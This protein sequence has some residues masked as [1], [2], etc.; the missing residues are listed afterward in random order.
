MKLSNH[1]APPKPPRSQTVGFLLIPGFALMSYSS[2]MEPLRAANHLSGRT[3]Y[4]WK[5]VSPDGNPVPASNGVQ[6]IPDH[7]VGDRIALDMLFV[8]AGGNPA[9]FKDQKTLQ[10][11]RG[12]ARKGTK[13][14]GVSGGPFILARAGLLSGHRCTIHWEHV[15]AFLEEFPDVDLT[16]TLFEADG[17]RLTCAGGI[18][19]L[20]MMNAIIEKVHGHALANSVSEWFLHT[21]VRA[22]DDPQRMAL[23][24]RFAVS[25]D[26]LLRVLE[27][28]EANLEGPVSRSELARIAKLS[29]RQLE[30]L[31]QTHLKRTLKEH[32]LDLRLGRARQ[33]L[34]ESSLSILEIAIACGFV[35]SSHFSRVYRVRFGRSPR[36]ERPAYRKS[37]RARNSPI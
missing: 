30:R 6:I 22:T 8:C 31:F 23:R 18:A 5:H 4:T 10:W 12:L 26:R 11:L 36:D 21:K 25:H 24:E 7:A 33:L 2:A 13:I 34:N 14:G 15:P 27:H 9:A 17:D 37:S 32:Y 20:D 28:M 3:L 19:S 35:S 29:L 16:R 1:D